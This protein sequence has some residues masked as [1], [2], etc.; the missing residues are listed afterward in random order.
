LLGLITVKAILFLG[1]QNRTEYIQKGRRQNGKEQRQNKKIHTE[2]PSIFQSAVIPGSHIIVKRSAVNVQ[3]FSPC[4]KKAPEI[5]SFGGQISV[6]RNKHVV[7]C[8]SKLCWVS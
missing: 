3:F 4:F 8:M 5:F 1:R 2:R 7:Y 6:M